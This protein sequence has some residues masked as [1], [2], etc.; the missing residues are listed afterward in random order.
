MN[1][2]EVR[3]LR[4]S[5][6]GR[7]VVQGIDLS[8]AEGEV[9][10]ILGPNG[11]GKTTT[12]EMIGGLRPRDVGSIRVAGFDPAAEEREFRELLGMQLQESRQ[13]AKIKVRESIELYRSFYRNPRATDELLERFGLADKADTRFEHLSGGQQQRLSVALALV[14][15]P[16]VAILDELTTGLDPAAR[17]EIWEFLGDLTSDGVTIMLVTHSMEE[18][19][20]L[21]DRVA[22]IDGGRVVALDSPAGLAHS[23][24]QSIIRFTTSHAADVAWLA[25]LPSVATVEVEGNQVTV[26]GSEAS[27]VAVLGGLTGAGIEFEGLRITAPSLDD[28]YVSLTRKEE[29]R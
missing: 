2:I 17:R 13:P 25:D 20:F 4:K 1:I 29:A 18:A 27:P 21:C 15:N 19:Q 26:R 12:V 7:P 6:S 11:A 14:G 8:V 28:A 24:A 16:R 22:I 23:G 3:D 5:Y 9:F 10:G